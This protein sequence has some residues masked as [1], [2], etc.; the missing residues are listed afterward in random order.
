MASR[1]KQRV[2]LP[3]QLRQ[4]IRD[5]GV[6]PAHVARAAGVDTGIMSRFMR[7]ERGISLKTADQLAKHLALELKPI[8]GSKLKRKAGK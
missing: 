6:L 1:K 4:A 8:K 5:S 7:D 3:E 2:G